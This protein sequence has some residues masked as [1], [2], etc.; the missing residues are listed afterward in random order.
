VSAR[1]DLDTTTLRAAAV[2]YAARGWPVL[3]LHWWEGSC[4]SCGNPSCIS[5]AK[6]PYAALAP[7]GL[8]DASAIAEVVTAWWRRE[9]R[10]NVGVRTGPESGLLVIDVDVRDDQDGEATLRHLVAGLGALPET[11]EAITGS[12][13]R[14]LLFRYPEHAHPPKLGTGV[15]VKGSGGYIVVAPSNH[16]SGREYAWNVDNHP[17][18]V[19]LAALP[20]AWSQRLRFTGVAATAPAPATARPI[21]RDTHRRLVSALGVLDAWDHDFWIKVG[22]ALHHESGGSDQGHGLWYEWS[23][24]H[25]GAQP[26]TKKADL[27][28]VRKKWA[29]FG[30]SG[31]DPIT[32]AFIYAEAAARG[33]LPPTVTVDLSAL[34]AVGVETPAPAATA[35]RDAWALEAP[36]VLADIVR[37]SLLG[38]PAPVPLY[39]LAGALTLASV[40]C[41]R[42]YALDGVTFGSLYVLVSG[43]SGSGKEWARKT[44]TRALVAASATHLVGPGDFSS[45]GAVL[46]TLKKQPQVVALLDEFGQLMAASKG[47]SGPRLSVS[48]VLILFRSSMMLK[49]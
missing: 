33:W 9:P 27:A 36:G 18:D 2:S 34:G 15:D 35:F 11:V 3:P 4:C 22:M 32:V 25:A 31:R 37:W 26:G 24:A 19:A 6:H 43:R 8:H 23:A 5:P 16:A 7:R 28:N 49:P 14:H 10:C 46:S 47:P 1:P 21:D 17:D 40:V 48:I 45:E 38:A 13:S 30:R 20:A 42:H 44:V 39:S 29:E 12:G 41:G